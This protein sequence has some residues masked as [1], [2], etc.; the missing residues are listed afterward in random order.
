MANA[1]DY[2]EL[3]DDIDDDVFDEQNGYAS[4]LGDASLPSEAN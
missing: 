1:T 4:P 3:D 2:Y